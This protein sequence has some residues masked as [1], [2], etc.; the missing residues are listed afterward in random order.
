[1]DRMKREFG[2]EANVGNPQVAYKE[3]ILKE[4][5][6]EGKYIRQTGG[7]GQYGHA[8]V[9]VKPQARSQGNDFIDEVVGGTI[10]RE[11][12]P[13]VEK[14]VREA[15][16]TG[17]VAGYPVIDVAVTL[18]DGSYHEVDSSEAAFK[19]AGSLAVQAAMKRASPVLLEPIMKVEVIT[20]QEFMGDAV[21]DINAK[22]GRIEGI[23][24]RLNVKVIDAIVPL[25]TMFGYATTIRSMTQG[26]A[27]FTMEF[28][29][30]E[31]VP[32]QIADSIIG[33]RAKTGIRRGT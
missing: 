24:D 30:Y 23:A 22:R 20:P 3:T 1:V 17:V 16:V 19:I 6:G 10:P 25:A 32:S 21:G 28:S 5:E 8:L 12:I 7:R 4:A 2:V 18:F 31:T 27:T 26:R 13:A 33:S 11:Y 9:R 29:H 14:G 15:L